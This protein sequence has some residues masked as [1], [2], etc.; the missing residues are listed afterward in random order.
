MSKIFESLLYN[1]LQT[2]FNS[3]NLLSSHK[4]GY[5]RGLGTERAILEFINLVMPALSNKEFCIIVF[6][7]YSKCFDTLCRETL[8]RKFEKY[9]VRGEF[10]DFIKS[11]LTDRCQMVQIRSALS[12][13]ESQ[14]L[15]VIQGSKN[16]PLM[17]DIYSGDFENICTDDYV[18]CADDTVIGFRGTDLKELLDHVNAKLANIHKWCNSNKLSL[19][20]C[21]SEYMIL[22][23]KKLNFTPDITIGNNP[24]NRVTTVK[25]LGFN[26]DANLKH[27]AHMT[28][29]KAALSRL[30]GISFRLRKKFNLQAARQFYYGM[31]YSNFTYGLAAY[32]G[33]FHVTER[34]RPI[35]SAQK[36][37]MKNLFTKF[38]PESDCLF[39]AMRILKIQDVYK[40][41]VSTMMHKILYFNE[42]PLLARNLNLQSAQHSYNTPRK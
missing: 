27:H 38:Y 30:C 9:G 17:Y 32:G 13:M 19:N 8:V 3:N 22:S 36:R 12:N 25:Y 28:Q 31:V 10:L 42:M 41:R 15:G 18:L 5:R 40:L 4:Y 1:R 14:N 24:V 21:K 7:D 23:N 6:L 16:G 33:V 39:K 11:Y 29:V 37:I 2:F 35:I 26:L 20:A 34:G